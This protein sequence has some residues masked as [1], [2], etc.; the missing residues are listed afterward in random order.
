MAAPAYAVEFQHVV[1]HLEPF[2]IQYGL[3]LVSQV[4]FQDYVLDPV[5][6]EAYK[7]MM[8]LKGGQ[9]I[10]FYPF[11]QELYLLDNASFLEEGYLPVNCRPVEGREPG[12][13][14]LHQLVSRHGQAVAG[15]YPD[16]GFP[17]PGHP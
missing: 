15:E 2:R 10:P 13:E 9:L 14:K 6:P 3:F 16:D 17:E 12:P 8:V 4:V 1:C 11:V 7:V 5:A